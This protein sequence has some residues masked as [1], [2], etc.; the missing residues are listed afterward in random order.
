[1][2]ELQIVNEI[3][4]LHTQAVSA[5]KSAKEMASNAV[6]IAIRCGILLA[7]QKAAVGHGK[8]L[9]WLGNHCPEL[10]E[11]TA[12]RYMRLA[13]KLG[14]E[15]KAEIEEE[16]G[17]TSNT[18]H[19]RY[20]DEAPPKS[21]RQAYI[22]TGILPVAPKS[23]E[24]RRTPPLSFVKHIDSLVLWFRE[25]TEDSPI[26]EWDAHVRDMLIMHLRPWMEV[27]NQ[28]ID[29]NDKAGY[30]V[31]KGFRAQARKAE[32]VDAYPASWGKEK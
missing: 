18:A 24:V 5:S 29:L 21:I 6:E 25:K 15:S 2:N 27:Y 13:R 16:Q 17:N 1:M 30:N 20:L 23:E 32:K 10:G 26:D 4:S 9:E 28:L 11:D 22:A 12:Q 19:V 31:P 14:K 3:N 7:V 8:W